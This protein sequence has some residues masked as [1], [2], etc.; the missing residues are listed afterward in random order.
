MKT[1]RFPG[2]LVL[3]CVLLM[4]H[5][6]AQNQ[7][8]WQAT[9][10]SGA[11]RG[12]Q[13]LRFL[14]SS[15]GQPS[16]GISSGSGRILSSGYLFIHYVPSGA[17][18]IVTQTSVDFGN[19]IVGQ[20]AARPLTVQNTGSLPLNITATTIPGMPWIIAS[21]GGAQT[22]NPGGSITMQLQFQP[23]SA[24][25]ANGTLTIASN[26][27]NDPSFDVA[28]TGVGIP[29]APNLQVSST[30][31][32][33]GA[34]SVG[35]SSLRSVTLNNTGNA[36]LSIS[37]QTISGADA[38]EFTITHNSG[39]NIGASGNDYIEI[40]FM[41]GSSGAKTA[42]LTIISNDPNNPTTTVNLS[43][44]G[45]SS[46]VPH[47][48][49]STSLLD[50]GTT[51][52]STLVSRSVV[53]SNSGSATLTL[54]SQSVGGTYFTLQ[55]AGS[56]SIAPGANTTAQIDFQP[57]TL[58]S[59]T[60]SFDISSNDPSTPTVSVS[61][62]GVCSPVSGPRISLSRTVIDF[63][64]VALLSAK[65]E[66][67]IVRN[68]GT[69]DLTISQQSIT[70]TDALHFSITQA[71]GSPVGPGGSSTVRI[72]HLPTTPGSK[73]ALLRLTT[74]DPGQP[75]TEVV[76][77]STVVG[78]DKL[79]K[80]PGGI[81]LHQNYPNP[82]ATG[83]TATID[84]E[85]DVPGTVELVVYNASGQRVATLDNSFRAAGVYRASFQALDLPSGT[86]TAQLVLSRP[87]GITKSDR[88]WITLIR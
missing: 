75:V 2:F 17:A 25:N 49:V 88:I 10:A 5:A 86:Y 78:I 41:P 24:G 82:I 36:N 16:V 15:S 77:I 67:L 19:V 83:Q 61:L 84:Y 43:G 50:F 12:I 11:E 46:N 70:G 65:E 54:T 26:A 69:S 76:L 40:R 45:T 37:N 42:M 32:D 35:L 56:T 58:G 51:S 39:V 14:Y 53:I 38:S 74:N 68:T 31:L 63:G 34:V 62:R 72:R 30:A 3:S 60:G 73:V 4:T 47:I 81:I 80:V 18:N 20:F 52:V 22:I 1:I 7:I 29:S 44:S 13:G 8:P 21:G 71:A 64:Q 33:F 79:D 48:S 55:I 28:L 57:A 9:D 85:V 27:A 6:S 87:T 59:Y 23:N 66:D